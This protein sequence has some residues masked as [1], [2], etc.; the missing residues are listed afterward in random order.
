MK[1]LTSLPLYVKLFKRLVN[2]HGIHRTLL[3]TEL[4]AQIQI[5]FL[6]EMIIC[7]LMYT[8]TL[9]ISAIQLL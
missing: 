5:V 2:E 7:L 9:I 8:L 6:N 4:F 3:K 1:F